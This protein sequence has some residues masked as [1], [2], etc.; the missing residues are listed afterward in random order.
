MFINFVRVRYT[1]RVLIH[2]SEMKYENA[3]KYKITDATELQILIGYRV[4]LSVSILIGDTL[5]LVGSLRYNAIKLHK[6]IVIFV[7]HMAAADILMAI[8]SIIPGALSLAT[9]AWILGEHI[10]YLNYIFNSCLA[11]VQSL[12]TSAMAISKML[13]VKY[14]LR[15]MNFHN[16]G[17]KI[18]VLCIWLTGIVFPVAEIARTKHE[19]FFSYEVYIC[20]CCSQQSW[21]TVTH[22]IFFSA[23]GLTMVMSILGT[24]I[25]S[26]ML[27]VL[28]RKAAT[29][30]SQRLQWRGVLTVLLTAAAHGILAL[31]LTVYYIITASTKLTPTHSYLYLY[32]YGWWIAQIGSAVNFFIFG[33]TLTSFRQFLKSVVLAKLARA[34][35]MIYCCSDVVVTPATEEE[36]ERRAL[37]PDLVSP[38]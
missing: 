18:A 32:R 5:I 7:Q 12:V 17:A 22:S 37:L 20:D 13:I 28:A 26:I 24:L 2:I 19:V 35:E 8:F 38:S 4:L 10:C 15:A 14:P 34:F 27:L 36:G 6:I 9:N 1:S 11:E 16:K 3:T 29:E 31:P 23:V 30:R 25:S 21:S 33:L